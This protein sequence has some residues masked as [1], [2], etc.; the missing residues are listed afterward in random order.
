MAIAA[1]AQDRPSPRPV[2]SSLPAIGGA[3]VA[4]GPGPAH[5]GQVEG[6]TNLPVVGAINT[7][8]AHP[9]DANTLWIGAANGG[10]WKT[11]NATSG[12]PTWTPQTDAFG[13]LSI[14]AFDIDP[15][16]SNIL[17]AGTG[18][19]SSWFVS[20]PEGRLLRTTNGG[21]NWTELTP[22][23]L[24]FTN[25]TGIASRGSTIVVTTKFSCA[26]IFLSTDSGATFFQLMTPALGS[27]WDL[28]SD[29]TNSAVLY[30]AIQDNC[31]GGPSGVYKSTDTG[32]SWT[33]VSNTTMN[34]QMASSNNAE[35]A[36]GA[37]GQVY[38]GIVTGSQLGGLFRSGNGGS[39]WTQLDTPNPTI[40]PGGQGFLHFSLT[41]DPSNVNLMYVGGDRQG[42]QDNIG[43]G[44]FSGRLFRV[45]AAAAPGSQATPLTHC[46]TA[47]SGC[48][49]SVSTFNN[50]APHA[51][52]RGLTFLANGTLV[53]VDDG[54]IYR[55]SNPS[56]TGDWSSM[57]GNLQT[58][59]MHDVAY[60]GISNMV[61]SGNQDTG[62]PEQ[63]SVGGTT[64]NSVTT[65][66]GGDASI[67]DTTSPTQ[68]TRYSSIQNLGSFRRRTVNS[69][70]TT[71]ST[72]FPAHTVISGPPFQPQFA[73]PVELNRLDQ[74][75]ILFA[76]SN[77]LYESLDRGD[78]MSALGLNQF[79]RAAVFGG[80]S[81]G[82]DNLDLI[83]AVSGSTVYVRTSGGGAPVPTASQPTSDF[84]RDIAVD[85]NN[86][87]NAYIVTQTGVVFA[88]SNA[89]ASWSNVTGN[90]SSGSTD[91]WTITHIPGS[92]SLVAVGGVN[93][94]F[95]MAT[96]NPGVWNQ[97]GTGMSNAI[98]YDL[99]YESA[100]DVLVAGTLGRGAWKLA[101]V[102]GIP[103][104]PP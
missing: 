74:R 100:D 87:Q 50:S 59:E 9:T 6:I 31:F 45:N 54:G 21:T 4:Q 28:A 47:L 55:R 26:P 25:I 12:S 81:G 64:W 101:N 14:S 57:I 95:R 39:T 69:S 84:I 51:D 48:N 76:G 75:R 49:G 104:D 8:V 98:V 10:I 92:P 89:G 52:S 78:T 72:I 20:G 32:A 85:V 102:I 42:F 27:A 2:T 82:V 33:R 77:D 103:P 67:D 30:T 62:T 11:T 40:H 56:G 94:V 29:P 70:G 3:W 93:A 91:L 5:N 68:S 90:L 19:N 34:N 17:V 60:D 79:V 16:S 22:S 46:Q 13:S 61:M 38:V 24:Q 99:D 53:E 58:A 96:N 18:N 1:T 80:R 35:I 44:D 15:T 63:T 73:T 88:T 7:V 43:A 71:L 37:S 65:A 97:L 83:Y 86:W 23:A 41:A 66:D 36:V